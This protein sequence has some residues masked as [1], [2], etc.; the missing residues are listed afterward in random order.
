MERKAGSVIDLS[1]TDIVG[2]T[3]FFKNCRR[4]MGNVFIVNYDLGNVV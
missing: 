2:E 1:G 3:N 4:C